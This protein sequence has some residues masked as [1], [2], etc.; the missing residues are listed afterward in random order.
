VN[1][2]EIQEE[3]KR[4][5]QVDCEV[6]HHFCDGC[7]ARE[8]RIPKDVVLAG[9]LHKTNHHFVLSKGSVMIKN[10]N[11]SEILNAPHHG[12]T[13]P[14][15][16]RIILALEDSVMTTFHVTNLTDIDEIG[17]KILGEEL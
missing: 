13:L 1:V 10:G 12:Y 15:D 17:R 3:I 2:V 9:A 14:G 16:K 4:L 11:K 6:E 7:Y 8:M 5:P